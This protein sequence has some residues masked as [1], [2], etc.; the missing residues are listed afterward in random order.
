MAQGKDLTAACRAING[1][2]SPAAEKLGKAEY[3]VW[4][5][6]GQACKEDLSSFRD[7]LRELDLRL[8]AVIL[9]VH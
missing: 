3:D 9:Q 5:L 6:A 2:I 1:E 8:A 4:D 7:L